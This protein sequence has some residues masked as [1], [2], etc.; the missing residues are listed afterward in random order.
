MIRNEVKVK[1]S[2]KFMF[3]SALLYTIIVIIPFFKYYNRTF[4]L[5]VIG[6]SIILFM[7]G[8]L[9]T[10]KNIK[11]NLVLTI[12]ICLIF[13][14]LN[15][16]GQWKN[17]LSVQEKMYSYVLFWMPLW[18]SFY[19]V[20][21]A[22]LNKKL[23]VVI[24]VME[25]FVLI[26]TLIG[27]IQYPLASRNLASTVNTLDIYYK[28]NIGGY[29]FIYG[30]VI[31]L[32]TLAI[33]LNFKSYTLV[34]KTF[35]FLGI[36]CIFISQ[37]STAVLFTT[38]FIVYLAFRKIFK[39]K[40]AIMFIYILVLLLLLLIITPVGIYSNVA[41]FFYYFNINA[42]GDKFLDL[43]YLISKGQIIGTVLDRFEKYNKSIIAFLSNPIIGSASSSF[44]VIGG[45]AEILDIL[46][47]TGLLGIYIFY[48]I[49][50]KYF[51]IIKKNI[52]NVKEMTY[53]KSV[54]FA[55]ILLGFL[56]TFLN[57]PLIS[58]NVFLLPTL[59][60]SLLKN[61]DYLNERIVYENCVD[62]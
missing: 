43:Y 37:Y 54:L 57:S 31:M 50:A 30:L 23:L 25:A 15:Y 35:I 45:H 27:L 21:K 11:N 52:F 1:T 22:E 51:N 3:T 47:S 24:L 28:M 38:L 17:Y 2:L 4:R 34:I 55:F 53:V 48:N 41:S 7:I 29:D 33:L 12:I 42:I 61:R 32:P 19:F 10:S 36:I 16:Y 8:L 60:I 39:D 40:T 58:I 62:N 18:Y 26:S 13:S 56:N 20:K 5:I 59:I 44:N 46:G 49:V 9:L 14:L 6:V